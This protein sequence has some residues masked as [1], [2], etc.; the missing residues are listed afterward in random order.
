MGEGRGRVA[1][2]TGA[3]R[4]CSIHNRTS[5]KALGEESPDGDAC[6]VTLVSGA[7]GAGACRLCSIHNRTSDKHWE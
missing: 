3:C 2:G 6:S 1:Y 5:D 4:P 7:D